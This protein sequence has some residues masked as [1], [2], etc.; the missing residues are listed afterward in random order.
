MDMLP[1][2]T[3]PVSELHGWEKN[4]R[5]IKKDDFE[6]LKRQIQKLGQYKPL[7]ITKDNEVI[8]GNMRLK[9]YQE[10]GIDEVWVSVVDPK[11][12]AEKLE[13]ALSDND[14]AGFYDSDL[15]A[16]LLPQYPDFDWTQYAV[17]LKEPQTLDALIQSLTPV[18]E[19]EVPEVSDEEPISE[20]GEVYQLGRH[21][22][23]CGDSTKIEDIEKLMKGQKADMVFTDPPY[24]DLMMMNARK[25]IQAKV[26][27]YHEYVGHGDFDFRPCWEIINKWDCKKVIWGGNYFA[28]YLPITTSW[29][30]W[31]KRAGKHSYFSDC[32]LA[33]S[34]VGTPAKV[35]SITWQGMIRQGESDKRVHPTQKP[36]ELATRIMD[37]NLIVDLFGGSGSTLIACEQANRIC[38]M[39]EIDPRYCDVIRKRYATFTGKEQ[40][41]Q[42]LTPPIS[43]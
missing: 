25:E 10:L 26:G 12:E 41:W 43:L 29:I 24:G 37:G 1:R 4:P 2:D 36:I 42:I 40:E 11:D 34:N 16:N 35:Y 39:M 17:D 28:D 14:R 33:W 27:H 21:R 20:Y 3:R 15:I 30:V 31:D 18:E 32:E 6:R 7:L 13:Y 8:G 9:A 22:L 5:S 19:D 23:M 38:Y